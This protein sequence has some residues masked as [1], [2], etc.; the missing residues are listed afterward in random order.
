MSSTTNDKIEN[1]KNWVA[2]R[3]QLGADV[4][5]AQTFKRPPRNTKNFEFFPKCLGIAEKWYTSWERIKDSEYQFIFWINIVV[6]VLYRFRLKW[7]F[8]PFDQG[9]LLHEGVES[10]GLGILYDLNWVSAHEVEDGRWCDRM[11]ANVGEVGNLAGRLGGV[12]EAWFLWMRRTL[13]PWREKTLNSLHS[14]DSLTLL[15]FIHV[16]HI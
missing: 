16:R 9:T 14:N 13:Q 2:V 6:V 7:P 11:I 8:Q 4:S 5:T 1:V 3:A 10:A 15:L 12:M